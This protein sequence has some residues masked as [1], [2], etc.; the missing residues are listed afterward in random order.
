[1]GDLS[2]VG[3]KLL[4]KSAL[5]ALLIAHITMQTAIKV[6]QSNLGNQVQMAGVT[7]MWTLISALTFK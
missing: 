1:M 5:I 3:M 2:P 4:T 6:L 7:I